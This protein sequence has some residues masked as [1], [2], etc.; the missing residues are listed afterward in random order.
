MIVTRDSSLSQSAQNAFQND[1]TTEL[2]CACS[3]PDALNHI[4][5]ESHC[6]LMLDLQLPDMDRIDMVRLLSVAKHFPILA[7]TDTLSS[8]EKVALLHAGVDAFLEKPIDARL[9]M[10]QS[11][12]L[13]ELYLKTDEQL[14][15]HAPIVFG[16]SLVIAP[17]Y[18]RVFADGKPL[19][20]TRREFD[21]LY[22]LAQHPGQVF[23]RTQLY[24]Q[25][26][27]DFYELGGDET[28]KAHI[29]TLRK[30]LSVLDTN[31]IENEWGV[32]YRFVPP[33]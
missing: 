30:K 15:K 24:E 31:L 25:V 6:L 17:R 11:N 13:V 33:L 3:L 19:E 27:G 8:D 26:W 14:R 29:K 28:V 23:T 32:G 21:L 16:T 2:R 4:M 5:Q 10:A 9:C 1:S 18:R 22:Y 7:L 12:A 20:L